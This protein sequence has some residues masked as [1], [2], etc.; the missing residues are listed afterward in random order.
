MIWILKDNSLWKINIDLNF[1]ID[2]MNYMLNYFNFYWYLYN[3]DDILKFFIYNLF[4]FLLIFKI[5][6]VKICFICFGLGIIIDESD[7]M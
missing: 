6:I 3:V 1:K 2:L 4:F 5:F 7:W